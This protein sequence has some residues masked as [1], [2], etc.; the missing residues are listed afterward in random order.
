[1]GVLKEKL[2]MAPPEGAD[3]AGGSFLERLAGQRIGSLETAV[4]RVEAAVSRVEA[5]VR[6]NTAELQA[7]RA[8]LAEKARAPE[9]P[10]D[11]DLERTDSD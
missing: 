7:C 3:A 11:A 5:A 4:G 8:L 1:M 2:G 10:H 6:E 9:P